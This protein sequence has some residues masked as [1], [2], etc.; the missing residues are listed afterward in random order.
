MEFDIIRPFQS[1]GRDLFHL[2]YQQWDN[3][4]II[5]HSISSTLPEPLVQILYPRAR[6]M[7]KPDKKMGELKA[8]HL[9]DKIGSLAMTSDLI[10]DFQYPNYLLDNG[11]VPT[12]LAIELMKAADGDNFQAGQYFSETIKPHVL[13]SFTNAMNTAY[14][15]YTERY[16]EYLTAVR[17]SDFEACL[18]S[19]ELKS[20]YIKNYSWDNVFHIYQNETIKIFIQSK[21][22]LKPVFM[23]VLERSFESNK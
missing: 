6:K 18:L 4:G 21:S 10:S 3:Y 22:L 23:I 7:L 12:S 2:R 11:R 19:E 1:F 14:Y 9:L 16:Y 8:N 5:E 13:Y 17:Q 20:E 15:F